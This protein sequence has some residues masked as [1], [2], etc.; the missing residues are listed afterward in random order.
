[1]DIANQTTGTKMPRSD[2]NF[3]SNANL[4]IPGSIKEQ[5][6]I[7]SILNNLNTL[8]TLHQRELNSEGNDKN[9]KKHY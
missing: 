1:M 5:N 9:G 7:S 4:K 6:A 3:V 2:W 8:I